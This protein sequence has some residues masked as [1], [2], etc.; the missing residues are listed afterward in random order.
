[1]LFLDITTRDAQAEAVRTAAI[2]GSI[3]IKSGTGSALAILALGPT[4]F[5]APVNGTIQ[6]LAPTWIFAIADGQATTFE[7]RRQDDSLIL[8]GSV[9]VV[10]GDML[11][12]D[13]VVGTGDSFVVNTLTYTAP[14]A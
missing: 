12:T 3:T 6:L 10:A 7:M 5:G 11:V 8:I 1:M 9:G 2:N 13:T 14:E 4:P